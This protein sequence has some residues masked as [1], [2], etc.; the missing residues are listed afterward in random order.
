MSAYDPS[1]AIAQFIQKRG[2][3]IH[4]LSFRVASGELDA[5]L[6]K[7]KAKGYRLIYET[8]RMGAH[9]MRINFIHPSSAGGM[10]IEVME[11]VVTVG[12]HPV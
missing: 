9:S 8:P 12:E 11:P 7:L 10:L 3:G 5:L 2:P 6:V 4:H 1:S